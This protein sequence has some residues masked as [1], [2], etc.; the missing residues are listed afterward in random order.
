MNQNQNAPLN[1][2]LCE[3]HGSWSYRPGAL[4]IGAWSIA[5]R[6]GIGKRDPWWMIYSKIKIGI[7]LRDFVVKVGHPE[8]IQLFYV[9]KLS[10]HRDMSK[11]VQYP[12]LQKVFFFFKLNSIL[13]VKFHSSRMIL[14]IFISFFSG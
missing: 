9:I 4:S 10:K 5:S 11:I 14:T 1:F 2:N 7:Y 13:S 12:L 3:W 8:N 6:I